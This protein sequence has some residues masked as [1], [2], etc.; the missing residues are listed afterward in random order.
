MRPV[1]NPVKPLELSM[2]R[3]FLALLALAFISNP[4]LAGSRD[5]I[6]MTKELRAKISAYVVQKKIT[7]TTLKLKARRGH[8][9]EDGI[10]LLDVPA[11]WGAD[12]TKYK[13]VYA[14]KRILFIEPGSRTVVDAFKGIP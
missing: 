9:L 3:L 10:Q 7:P 8:Q 13:Y 2:K 11:E 6:N 5:K 12:L 4:V 1:V 14:G